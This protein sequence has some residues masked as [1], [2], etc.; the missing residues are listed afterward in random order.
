[1]SL[2]LV[3][4]HTVPMLVSPFETWCQAAIPEARLLHVLD[5]P[6]LERIR[7][8]G[9]D[10]DRDDEHL[11]GH[12]RMA[13]AIG[14]AGLLVTCSSVSRV[15]SRIRERTTLPVFGIDEAMAAQAARLGGRIIILATELTTL[16]PTLELVESA[17]AAAGTDAY[18]S[19]RFVAGAMAALRSGDT[20]E[21]DR[22]LMDV[23]RAEAPEADVI[24][25]AQATMA[26]VL[27]ALVDESVPVPVLGSPQ[28]ALAAVRQALLPDAVMADTTLLT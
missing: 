14:A 2:T 6:A 23:I 5:E 9:G 3:L 16:Q 26:R 1:V 18:V 10:D 21:H 22:L 13:E 12:V 17:V 19:T 15:V 28:L 7:Q 27:D 4:L 25:L 20:A 24:V 11:L 8:R